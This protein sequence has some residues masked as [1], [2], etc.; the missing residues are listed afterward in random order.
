MPKRLYVDL[1]IR[2]GRR[3]LQCS[4]R[5]SC[6]EDEGIVMTFSVYFGCYRN[7]G[8]L[9]NLFNFIYMIDYWCHM[10]GKYLVTMIPDRMEMY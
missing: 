3:Q 10:G 9:F 8:K 6:Q 5:D 4:R 1:S 7:L 2:R